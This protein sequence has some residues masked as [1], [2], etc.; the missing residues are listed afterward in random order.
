M[1][2]HCFRKRALSLGEDP[3]RG[4]PVGRGWRDLLLGGE[5][6]DEDEDDDENSSSVLELL[7]MVSDSS[8]SMAMSL[9]VVLPSS[10]EVEEDPLLLFGLKGSCL[11]EVGS[12][13]LDCIEEDERLGGDIILWLTSM[14]S[15]HRES[16]FASSSQMGRSKSVAVVKSSSP[17]ESKV[18]Q[19]SLRDP[20]VTM[21]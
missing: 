4:A 20:L 18:V 9:E 8:I 15:P 1:R 6:K 14:E 19:E 10:S 21:D 3:P 5:G 11:K 12:C 16:V 2:S 7:L 17:D 13:C